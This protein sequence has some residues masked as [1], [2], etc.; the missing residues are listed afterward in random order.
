VDHLFD[1]GFI[2]FKDSGDILVS[3]ELNPKVLKQWALQP[4]QNVGEFRAAQCQYLD[5]HRQAIF[6]S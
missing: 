4:S 2:S 5:Y 6:Q 1:R 3:K